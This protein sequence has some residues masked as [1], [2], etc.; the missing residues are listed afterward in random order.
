MFGIVVEGLYAEEALEVIHNIHWVV[1]ELLPVDE[2]D[3]RGSKVVQPA[4]Q[5]LGIHPRH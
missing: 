1:P 5:V 4:L 2:D 3:L